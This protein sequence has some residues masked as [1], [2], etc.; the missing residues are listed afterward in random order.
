MKKFAI[1]QK[2]DLLIVNI[3]EAES[4]LLGTGVY[5]GPWNDSAKVMH[6]EIPERLKSTPQSE[7]RVVHEMGV[8][9][10]Q[11]IPCQ[12]DEGKPVFKEVFTKDGQLI[13]D[14]NG[15]PYYAQLF[16]KVESMGMVYNIKKLGE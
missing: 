16:E 8:I 6:L 15:Y 1:V 14:K 2:S 9:G 10:V 12:C 7:L 3:Y 4:S 13:V 5:G 11:F